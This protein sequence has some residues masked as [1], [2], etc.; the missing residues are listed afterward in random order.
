MKVVSPPRPPAQK[1][2]SE[3]QTSSLL[4][5]LMQLGLVIAVLGTLAFLLSFLTRSTLA[6]RG[7]AFRDAQVYSIFVAFLG[8]GLFA[9]SAASFKID[10]SALTFDRLLAIVRN[11]VYVPPDESA[12]LIRLIAASL[13]SLSNEWTL[14]GGVGLPASKAG[15]PFALVGP[16]GVFGLE[17]NTED[18]R[19][20]SYK[21]PA[22]GLERACSWLQSQV[23]TPVSPVLLFP[24]RAQ[25]YNNTHRR[26]KAFTTEEALAWLNSRP[27]TLDA[28]ARRQVDGVLR[29]HLH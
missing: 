20:R 16:A 11:E 26:V 6:A 23:G 1:L 10:L 8:G 3:E 22:P 4:Y 5:R 2:L 13:S 28:S 19:K 7:I 18:P 9:L 15:L 25:D 21:D 12:H 24:R 29:S 17:L 27:E 14:Y